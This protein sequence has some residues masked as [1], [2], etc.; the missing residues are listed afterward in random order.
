M[1]KY[2]ALLLALFII[3]CA[4]SPDNK[5][6]KSWTPPPAGTV[7]AAD[8]MP[9]SNDP[10]IKHNFYIQLSV[11][12]NNSQASK[13]GFRYDLYARYAHGEANAE[14][15]MPLGGEQLR[16]IIRRDSGTVYTVGFI[17]GAAYGGDTSFHPY[18]RVSGKLSGI[19]VVAIKSYSFR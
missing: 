10:L 12:P 2:Y 13:Y 6:P 5:E 9:I 8:S 3:G 16:P 1:Q 15:V 18:Y 17:P 7:I 4:S 14:L 11:S 19:E